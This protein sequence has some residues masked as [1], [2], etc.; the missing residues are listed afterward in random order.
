M[1]RTFIALDIS[2]NEFLKETCELIRYRLRLE[3]V[4]WVNDLHITL[5]FLG[6]TE[7]EVIDTIIEIL[8]PVISG[9]KPVS[10]GLNGLDLFKN[11]HDPKVLWIGCDFP[12]HIL[13]MQQDIEQLLA[14]LGFLPDSRPFKPHLTLGRIKEIHEIKQLSQLVAQYRNTLFQRQ[15]LERIVFY[16]SILTSKG[17][18]YKPLHNFIFAKEA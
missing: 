8:D 12:E 10:F 14:P 5:K 3:R 7:E 18:V 15:L 11:I 9:Y 13:C 4:T 6:D 1:K 16:E 17:P 2:A